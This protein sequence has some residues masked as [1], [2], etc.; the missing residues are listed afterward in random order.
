MAKKRASKTNKN[1]NKIN[2]NYWSNTCICQFFLYRTQIW[3]ITM[4]N[5]NGYTFI[6]DGAKIL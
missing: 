1:N 5:D 6:N 3:S 4:A 2:W